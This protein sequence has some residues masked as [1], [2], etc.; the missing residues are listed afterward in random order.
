TA[1]N[2]DHGGGHRRDGP[3]RRPCGAATD[4]ATD[5]RVL[6]ARRD[7]LGCGGEGKPSGHLRVLV[8][9]T[10]AALTVGPVRRHELLE[11]GEVALVQPA[12]RADRDQLLDLVVCR[13]HRSIPSS[14]PRSF[15]IA[16][17]VRDFT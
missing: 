6:E 10:P 9:K 13:A 17:K 2:E 16:S 14:S 3:S 4:G 15:R 12:K 11:V 8:A 1:G 7:L 5:E